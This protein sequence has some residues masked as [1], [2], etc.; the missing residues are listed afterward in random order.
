MPSES[1]GSRDVAEHAVLRVLGMCGNTG[2]RKCGMGRKAAD[3]RKNREHH[4]R[5]GH[6]ERRLMR[7]WC[8]RYLP[9]NVRNIERNT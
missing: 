3:Q 5:H 6:H 8:P 7:M 1:G 4:Q 2:S 9:K